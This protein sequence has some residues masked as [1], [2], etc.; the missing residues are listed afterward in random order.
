MQIKNYLILS[1][2]LFF[3]TNFYSQIG[4]G[5]TNPSSAAMLEVS[6]RTNDAGAYRGLMP[7]RVPNIAARAA[8][9][10]QPS[11]IGL[12]VFV[13]DDGNGE[14]CLQIWDGYNW[15]DGICFVINTAPVASAVTISGALQVDGTLTASFTYTDADSD[16]AGA[17]IYTW[18]LAD[19]ASGTAQAVAQTGTSDTFDLLAAHENKFIAVEVTPVATSGLSPGIPVISAYQGSITDPP[20]Y[21]SDLFISEYV[22]GSS[23]NKAIEIANFTGSP[24]NLN[25]YR[26]AVY[27][28]VNHTTP[29]T[30]NFIPNFIL[31]HGSVYVIKDSGATG[32]IDADQIFGMGFNGDD[33]VAL[34][35]SAGVVIDVVGVIGTTQNFGKDKTLRKKPET[36]PS[37]TYNAGDYDVFPVDTFDG[38][39]SHQY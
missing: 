8:I 22:E 20:A 30:Q 10:P 17:H 35:N 33:P 21:A 6:S 9:S 32:D 5:T 27:A 7:P 12:M 29:A 39:G 26:Y 18:Y 34:Q 1:A 36:G 24:I 4:I 28:T 16:P 31:P 15:K 37:T 23:N 19:D 11:D 38:L 3:A 2:M 25:G 13:V 14:A